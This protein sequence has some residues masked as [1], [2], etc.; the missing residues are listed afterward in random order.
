MLEFFKKLTADSKGKQ[1][2]FTFL[3]TLIILLAIGLLALSSASAYTALTDYGNSAYYLIRQL[4]FAVAGIIVMIVISKIDYKVYKNWSYIV[5]LI[6][7]ALMLL[8]FVP[9]LG[10]EVKGARRWLNLGLFTFQ[11]SEIMKLGLILAISKYIVD[12]SKKIQSWKGYILP[13]IATVVVC[14]IMYFQSHLSGAIV[15]CFIAFVIILASGFKMK[16][17][18]IIL[19]GLIGI[20]L[21]TAFLFSEEYRLE[22]VKAF[23]NPEADITGGNW[24][25]TQSLYAI[26]SGGLF[27]RGLG[28]SRQK[29][30]WLPEA[31]NDFVFSVY[32][33]EFG[34]VG[35][36]VVVGLFAFLII[37]GVTIGLKSKDLYGMLITVGIIGM[38]AFQII[39]NIAVVTKLMPTTGMPL[40]FFSYGGTSLVINLAAMG[41]VLGV[42]RQTSVKKG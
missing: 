39:V 38:F 3:F 25:P 31:Q 42:S 34:F 23:L 20:V 28:Q 32:A 41:I 27:G 36:L 5:F 11:P 9:G 40:P 10:M 24:Q 12:N 15:M 13:V 33:E 1:L 14:A 19:I 30:L 37:R 18:T 17:R 22:R 21:V 16:T 29:Y 4:L 35:S 7:M 6:A 2:D 8:V 26:G